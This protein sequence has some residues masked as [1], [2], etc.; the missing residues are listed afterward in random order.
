MADECNQTV[1][2]VKF[3]VSLTNSSL[4]ANAV[5]VWDFTNHIALDTLVIYWECSLDIL[6]AIKWHLW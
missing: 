2:L 1:R 5:A 6:Y 3:V 4:G